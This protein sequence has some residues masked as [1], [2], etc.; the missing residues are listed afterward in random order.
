MKVVIDG[1]EIECSVEEYKQLLHQGLIG[2]KS[3]NQ[4]CLNKLEE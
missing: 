2:K 1:N 3:Q 4:Y